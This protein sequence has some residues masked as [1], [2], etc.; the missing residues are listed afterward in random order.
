MRSQPI[1]GDEPPALDD[2]QSMP[3]VNLNESDIDDHDVSL[4]V[5]PEADLNPLDDRNVIVD[6]Q[7]G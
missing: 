1:A 4:P 6:H 5:L 3:Q 2:E 7:L